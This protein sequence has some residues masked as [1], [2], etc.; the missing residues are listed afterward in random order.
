MVHHLLD[1]LAGEVLEIAGLE[2]G[3]DAFLDFFAEQLLLIRRSDLAECGGRIVD[4][5]GGFEDLL[6]GLFGT[7]DDG[8]E[9]AV[10]LGH[11][12]AVEALAMQNGNFA[13]GSGNG[14]IDQVEFDLQLLALLDLGPIGFKQ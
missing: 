1:A 9:F 2:N 5:F 10:D 12:L 14:I 13:L 11:F 7:A 4:G 6:G 8:T 3:D